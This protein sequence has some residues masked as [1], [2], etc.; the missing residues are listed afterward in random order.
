MSLAA[1]ADQPLKPAILPYGDLRAWL[2]QIEVGFN[3]RAIMDACRP[4]EWMDKFPAVSESSPEL[5]AKVIE[6]W[7]KIVGWQ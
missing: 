6:K 4:Y 3:S 7:A 1:Y 5:Q 2:R